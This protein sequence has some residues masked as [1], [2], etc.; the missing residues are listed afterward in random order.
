MVDSREVPELHQLVAA[1]GDVVALL[2]GAVPDDHELLT[3]LQ[4]LLHQE[5]D[6]RGL[7]VEPQQLITT[8]RSCLNVV[9]EAR[10][11]H[12]E[13]ELARAANA[14]QQAI[15]LIEDPGDK[16]VAPDKPVDACDAISSESRPAPVHESS[17]RGEFVAEALE[18]LAAAETA[19]LSLERAPHDPALINTVFRAFHTIKSGAGL[20]NLS[21]IKSLAH[22]AEGLL[23]RARQRELDLSGGHADLAFAAC[24]LLDGMVRS[25]GTAR[26]DND[27]V[28]RIQYDEMVAELSALSARRPTD[29]VQ[30]PVHA[31]PLSEADETLQGESVPTSD[32]ATVDSS[33]AAGDA[34]VRVRIERLDTIVNLIGELVVAQSMVTQHAD[35][36]HN[37]YGRLAQNIRHV[38]K[39]MHT[40]QDQAMSLRM[41][42]LRATFQKLSRLARDL[43]R[44]S[45]K[46]LHFVSEGEDTEIDRGMVERLNDALIHM[47]RNAIDHG[48][49]T[50]DIRRAA[51][52]NEVGT[53]I[54]R[55]YHAAGSV[56]IEVVDDGRGLDM[57]KI[58][59]VA[60]AKG[61]LRAGQHP[62]D[63]EVVNLISTPGFSTAATVTDVS[64]RGVGMDVVRQRVE[65]LRGRIEVR[66]ASGVGT[67]LA[68]RVPL[69]LAIIDAMLV[70]VGRQRYLMPT[71]SI[72][73]SF[74]PTADGLISVAGKGELVRL[75]DEVLR[76][77]RLGTFMDVADYI[78]EPSASI[79]VVIE[80]DGQRCAVQ[81]DS[82][83]GQQQVVIKSIAADLGNLPGLSGAAILG[84]GSVGFILDAAGII[85]AAH[86][87]VEAPLTPV[88]PA[89]TVV[90]PPPSLT[91][92]PE[93]SRS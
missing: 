23:E 85:E 49:E 24:D 33:I 3:T 82:L 60:V 90:A 55:G 37:P 79:F 6:V 29:D 39:I 93:A 89:P 61:L 75:R 14:V 41:V 64:G 35:I 46:R 70:T 68:L 30:I 44:K 52:K 91:P 71:V 31:P 25:L 76:V 56:V 26:D 27:Q 9:L 40:L 59:A 45:G 77:I 36:H 62:S 66:S 11:Q 38:D 15:E 83:Q 65:E 74:R 72:V 17:L 10:S 87:H 86:R 54:L 19:L 80:A 48:L 57:A 63:S 34:T 84:N 13:E 1:L 58:T 8:A 7:P 51:H 43:A 67:T 12:P 69:T 92:S 32:V 78:R 81:V 22:Q 88:A 4:R 53:L 20:L 73:E 21:R 18:H 28:F 50:S 42:P 16:G 5:I 2:V 47:V